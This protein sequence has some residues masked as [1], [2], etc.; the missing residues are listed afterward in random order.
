MEA[1]ALI[2]HRGGF[3]IMNQ[4]ATAD[5]VVVVNTQGKRGAYTYLVFV[6]YTVAGTA[7]TLNFM[8]A[9]SK[10][11]V[12][13]E[14][15]AAGTALVVDAALTDGG[16]NAIAANDYLAIELE[17]GLWHVST[18]SAWNG[19]TKTATLNTAI[20]TGYTARKNADVRC[21]GVPADTYHD[22]YEIA[23]GTSNTTS[24]P[25]VANA[26]PLMRSKYKNEPILLY[27]N[28]ATAAGTFN[29]VAAIYSKT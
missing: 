8:R 16:G 19:T 3:G 12:A 22:A 24:H 5:T 21:Y 29:N 18:I 13:T 2:A 15:A 25:A 14:L 27:S 11:K 20:P 10:A 6:R 1:P 23:T 7:H 9:A 26:G 17:D 28:N 4:S